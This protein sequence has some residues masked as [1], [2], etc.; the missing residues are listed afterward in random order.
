MFSR[1]QYELIDFGDGRKLE[2]FAG[3]LVDRPCPAA[4]SMA[5]TDEALWDAD[6]RY[7]R[8]TGGEGKWRGGQ[9]PREPWSIAHGPLI[10]ELKPTPFG[11]LGVFPEQA[12]H[13]DWIAERVRR[14]GRPLTAGHLSM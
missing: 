12:P 7:E 11:H 2:R 1:D 14:A 6:A 9:P 10:L 13:W 4:E 3:V 5:K 8:G